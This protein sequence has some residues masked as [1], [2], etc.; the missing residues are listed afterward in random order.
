MAG[1]TSRL[2]RSLL[3]V[4]EREERLQILCSYDYVML[5]LEGENL[6]SAGRLTLCAAR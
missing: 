4:K 5:I 6:Q 3:S 2:G 1:V